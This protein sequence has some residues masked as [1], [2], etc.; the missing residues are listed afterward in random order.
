[1]NAH[2]LEKLEFDRIRALLAE[3]CHCSLGKSLATRVEPMRRASVVH[4]WMTQIRQMQSEAERIGFPPIGG[5]QDIREEIQSA[6]PSAKL[7]P[8]QLA[9]VAQTLEATHRLQKWFGQLSPDSSAL[10][11]LGER[12]GDFGALA[13]KLRQA[14]DTRGQL[15]DE[16]SGRLL[17]IRLSISRNR[18]QITEII[19]KLLKSS[20][21]RHHLQYPN[22]TFHGDRMVLPLKAN[23][24]GR[25]PGIIH[26]SSESGAT[27]FVEPAEAVEMNN[28]VIGL[29]QDEHEEVNRILWDLTRL[30]HVNAQEILKTLDVLAVLDLVIGKVKFALRFD[31]ICPGLNDD[32]M[33]KIH[34]ARHPLLMD[35][36]LREKDQVD[37][38]RTVVPID[39]RLGDDFDMLVI[40]GPN[41][42]GK[43]V[44]LKTVGL[45]CVMVQSGIPVPVAPDSTF[46]M[47]RDIL[48]DVGDEQSL[49]QSLSTFSSH[50][51]NI[52]HMLKHAGNNTL[53]LIDEM[54]AGTDPEEGAALGKSIVE[55]LLY[56]KVP[57]ILTT[58]MGTLKA[59]GFSNPRAYNAAVE[60]DLESLKPTFRLSIGEPG[61]SN[62]IEIAARL[63]MPKRLVNA[64]RNNLSGRHRAFQA[65]IAETAASRRRAE[66]ARE[67][68][69][70]VE[71]Q[72]Q[73]A[74]LDFEKKANEIKQAKD[75]FTKW[76]ARVAALKPGDEVHVRRFDRTGVVVRSQLHKQNVLVCVGAI[77][78]EVPF[79]D[80]DIPEKTN[81]PS[82]KRK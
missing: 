4:R 77:E 19:G 36:F 64:A 49:E 9:V 44:A 52:L 54:G 22:S 63:G 21:I 42:G 78:M 56:K 24:R 67:Q 60:F 71:S 61:N 73:T 2:T 12:V 14:I 10:I 3:Q 35:L 31:A 38:Q 48:I 40:T 80:I 8:E 57:T 29:R 79:G 18:S 30:V 58:H 16:A 5:V 20:Q 27:L 46:P 28:V 75:D 1:M 66:A 34:Q 65:A 32:G 7:E 53:V 50:M 72:A 26:R 76:S 41:T 6:V 55:E 62:A 59:I 25:I 69:E 33:L 23:S 81:G 45:L 17:K 37:Q 11:S 68:A 82:K 13:D 70:A 39:V 43:T 47:Y 74:R 15:R 51:S